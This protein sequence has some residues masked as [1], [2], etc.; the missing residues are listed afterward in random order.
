MNFSYL[1][2]HRTASGQI[3]LAH[4]QHLQGMLKDEV[5]ID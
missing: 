1:G 4:A 5:S 3:E 2:M